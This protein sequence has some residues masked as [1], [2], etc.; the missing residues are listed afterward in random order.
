LADAEIQQ[1]GF[2]SQK[3]KKGALDDAKIKTGK[4]F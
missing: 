3:N 1:K 2:R 4:A